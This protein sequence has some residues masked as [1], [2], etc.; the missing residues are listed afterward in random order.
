[1]EPFNAQLRVW[2]MFVTEDP[3]IDMKN[4]NHRTIP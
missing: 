2:D 1:M 4:N 3:N